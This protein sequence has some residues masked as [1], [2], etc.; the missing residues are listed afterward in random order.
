MLQ[1]DL[2]DTRFF[3]AESRGSLPSDAE[4]FVITAALLLFHDVAYTS[5]AECEIVFVE[6]DVS[7]VAEC[8]EYRL[9][10][11][12]QD[13]GDG[14]RLRRRLSDFVGLR[15]GSSLR[16]RSRESSHPT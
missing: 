3:D 6:A 10:A 2:T 16:V 9:P 7:G 12:I 15:I 11:F 1:Y 13:V 8:I 4:M 14:S 5:L